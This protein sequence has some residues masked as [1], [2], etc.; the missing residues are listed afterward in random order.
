MKP[1]VIVGDYGTTATDGL[2][3]I[4]AALSMI[5]ILRGEA[6]LRWNRFF[7][8][9]IIYFIALALSA[10][11]SANLGATGFK[12]VTQVY[13]LALPVLVY[14][15]V[16]SA[17]DLRRAMLAWLAGS[18][19]PAVV[20]AAT[21]VL[22]YV[23]VDRRW[24]SGALHE[25][26]LLPPGNYPR[27]E[28]SFYFPAMLCNFLTTSVFV[29]FAAR[30]RGWLDPK[31]SDPL[32]A[33]IIVAAA[34]TVTPGLGGFVLALCLWVYWGN[35]SGP[36]RLIALIVGVAAAAASVPI[37][38]LTPIIHPTAPYLINV[39]G[40][41]FAPAVRLMT[42]T[43]AANLW[44]AHP[45]LGTDIGAAPLAVRFL[46][47]SGVLHVLTDAHNVYLNIAAQCGSAGLAALLLL[48]GRVVKDTSRF[49][50][51]APMP[52]TLVLGIAWVD[53][54]AIEGFTGSYEDA[55]HLWVL[56][57]LWL[58]S[59]AHGSAAESD[60]LKDLRIRIRRELRS[61]AKAP[62]YPQSS[63]HS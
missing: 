22:F 26:G 33:A 18:S 21:V 16:D 35:S 28:A 55:R 17:E 24:L 45:I 56:L 27:V 62:V 20:G 53:A 9:L 31:L 13:L 43:A 14:T 58:V 19:I 6:R 12:L 57:G 15:L 36:I 46:D 4:T 60:G 61:R 25:Y 59:I 29:L 40:M 42:W 11:A 7:L 39:G 23:G 41:T 38:T 48:I 49:R 1:A 10:V 52:L 63:R 47:P 5:A 37:S 51:G 54:F 44:L 32:L 2:F 8:I 30:Q 34:F 50:Q 3:L